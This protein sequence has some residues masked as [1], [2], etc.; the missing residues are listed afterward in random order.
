VSVTR[1]HWLSAT[2]DESSPQP[3]R[4]SDATSADT[5]PA[6]TK[7]V[8]PAVTPVVAPDLTPRLGDT[9]VLGN[10][11]VA[12]TPVTTLEVPL[13]RDASQRR[14]T[15]RDEAVELTATLEIPLRA[16]SSDTRGSLLQMLAGYVFPGASGTNSG[17]IILLF[18]V[19]LL[20]ATV[21]PRIPRLHLT[22]LVA[23]RGAGCPGY[24]P[25]ALRPG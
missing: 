19:A 21:T 5:P 3:N 25:V 13:Q 24:N 11:A 15:T 10:Q 1:A 4:T 22:T 14:T 2:V 16:T 23:Q 8:K 17:A 7:P 20:L 18:T 9:T 6:I 12:T